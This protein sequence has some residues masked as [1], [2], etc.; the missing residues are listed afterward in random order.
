VVECD[1]AVYGILID[2][3]LRESRVANS[4]GVQR[5]IN[6]CRGATRA[7]GM[8]IRLRG[9]SAYA[10]VAERECVRRGGGMQ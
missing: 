1:V 3:L 6:E 10:D 7:G 9:G 4:H 5:V 2:V 8:A